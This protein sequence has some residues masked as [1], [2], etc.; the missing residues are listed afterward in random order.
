MPKMRRVEIF[1][2]A[3]VADFAFLKE[4]NRLEDL[5]T[6]GLRLGESGGMLLPIC[7]LQSGDGN[8]VTLLSDWR[9]E[10][11]DAYPTR[12]PVTESGTAKWLK[13]K[14]LDVPDRIL[15]LIKDRHGNNVGH[16][17]FANCLGAGCLMEIDNVVRGVKGAS[18]GIMSEA[19]VA[20]LSWARTTLWP[21]G[22]FLRVLA[23]NTHAITFYQKIGFSETLRESL[24]L[25]VSGETSSLETV[26]EADNNPPDDYFLRMD[27]REEPGN[28]LGEQMILTAGPSISQR[29]GSYAYDAARYGWNNDWAKYLKQFEVAFTEYVGVKHAIATSSCTGALHI[30]LTALGIGP[31]DEVIV[32]DITWVATANAVLYVGATPVFADI[33]RDTWLLDPDSV[34]AKLSTRTKA[35]M[36]VHLYGHPCDMQSIM[37]IARHHG[38]FVVEDAAPSIGAEFQGQRTGSFGDFACFSFQGAKLAVTGEG[39]M[40]TTNNDSL[41]ERAYSIWDQGRKQ[42]TF[43]IQSNG[44]KYKMSNV[45]AAIGLGQLQRNDSMVEAKRRIFEW[46]DRRLGAFPNLKLCREPTNTR[47]IYWMTSAVLEHSSPVT[48]DQLIAALKRRKVDTR[49][50]FPAISQYPIWPV[51]Q[52]PLPNAKYIGDNAFNLPSGVCLKESEVDYVCGAILDIMTP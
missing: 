3:V 51:P 20:L 33:D 7:R 32:P 4:T 46:Y 8:L 36:P 14:L 52:A 40:L 22:F 11:S 37:Q 41:R 45:Q 13:E 47:S 2:K 21:E 49:P 39:G 38:L 1:R 26:D 5:Y 25:K 31:G 28:K 29:E 23:S 17:G 18:P 15:F 16:I 30:A 19:M 43:W 6:R 27:L 34:R 9:R 50:V 42:G 48:R 12:F 24:R 44:L 10:N 35:I